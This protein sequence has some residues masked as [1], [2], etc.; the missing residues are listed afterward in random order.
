MLRRSVSLRRTGFKRAT[1]IPPPSPPVTRGRG[2]VIRRIDDTVISVQKENVITSLV[3]Q[4]LVRTLPCARCGIVG[5]TQFC[6]S[7]EGKGLGIKTDDRRGWPGC[8]PHL[9][10]DQMVN[11]CHWFVGTSGKLKQA[12]RRALEARMSAVTRQQILMRGLWPK[13]LPF[14]EEDVAD[15]QDATFVDQPE[16]PKLIGRT[17]AKQFAFNLPY[18]AGDSQRARA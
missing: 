16:I 1:Y 8:G 9:D 14:W 17:F 12:E 15:F 13:S 4:A 2:G 6:H 10:G 3:Y 5:F 18:G 11:G 7:D